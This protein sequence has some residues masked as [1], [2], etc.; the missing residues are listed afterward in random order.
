MI[1]Q[2]CAESVSIARATLDQ[3]KD[4][5]CRLVFSFAANLMAE[6]ELPEPVTTGE[7]VLLGAELIDACLTWAAGGAPANPAADLGLTDMLDAGFED[8]LLQAFETALQQAID[9]PPAP[10]IRDAWR[11]ILKAAISKLADR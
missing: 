11:D 5:R 4:A 9:V 10:W 6:P 3:M 2:P 8:L 1:F 7:A